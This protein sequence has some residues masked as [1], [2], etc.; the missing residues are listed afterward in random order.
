[1]PP[2]TEYEA[3]RSRHA[4]EYARAI[5]RHFERI[6][7]SPERI[8]EEQIQGLRTL[9]GTAQA[10]SEWHRARLGEIDVERFELADLATLPTMTKEDLVANFDTVV[11]DRRIK[12]DLVESHLSTLA[13]DAYLFDEFH[14]VASGGSS[15]VRGCF[16]FGWEPWMNASLG[17][18]RFRMWSAARFGIPREGLRC[19]VAGGKA[20]HMSFAMTRTFGGA[21]NSVAVP[22]SLPLDVIVAKLNELH[23]AVLSGFASMVATLAHEQLAGRLQIQPGAVWTGS[24]PLLPEMRTIITEAWAVPIINSYGTSEGAFASDCGEGRGLH[25]AEDLCIFEPVDEAGRPV[26][27]GE[28][29]A[30]VLVTPFYNRTMPLIRYLITDEVT[31]LDGECPCGSGLRRI[32]DIAGRN[33]DLFRYGDTVIHPIAFRSVLGRHRDIVEYQVVQTPSGADVSVRVAA[34]MD[35]RALAATVEAELRRMGLVRPV[36]TVR[37]VERFERHASGK[38]KRFVPLPSAH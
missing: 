3:L 18:L 23:P 14:A 21:T 7:W 20:T 15:G 33:D 22:A 35:G 9:L 16:V 17:M 13:D 25:L 32:A 6:Q 1:M 12:R 5:P 8:R 2:M 19:V 24:E 26:A 36:V 27:V 10:Q 38:L 29:S 4:E 11:T 30:A 28:T 34:G 31:L 37:F